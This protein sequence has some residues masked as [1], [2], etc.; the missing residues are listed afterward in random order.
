VILNGAINQAIK[1]GILNKN[2]VTLTER[3][4][5]KDKEYIPYTPEE[6]FELIRVS[7]D[8]WLY[9][10]IVLEAYTGLRR[11]EL[12]AL[13][14]DDINFAE[15]YLEVKR[16]LIGYHDD[17]ADDMVYVMTDPKTD[18]SKRKVPLEPEVISVLKSHRTEQSEL[19]LMSGSSDFNPDN[20]VVCNMDGTLIKPQ[21][22]TYQFRALLKKN[23][24]RHVRFHDC[25]TPLQRFF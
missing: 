3:K 23:N 18:K 10:A 9:H 1:N 12:L 7:K 6:L 14:W 4:S 22:F 21:S 19:R 11:G 15:G 17:E 8:E 13:T 16:S 20:L 24:L 2:V 5:M 25:A